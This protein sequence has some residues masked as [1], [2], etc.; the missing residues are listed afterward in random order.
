MAENAG[1]A[2]EWQASYGKVGEFAELLSVRFSIYTVLTPPEWMLALGGGLNSDFGAS[3]RTGFE[4]C[5]VL[6][7]T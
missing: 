2:L 3:E 4:T 7:V 6:L 1:Y 5:K